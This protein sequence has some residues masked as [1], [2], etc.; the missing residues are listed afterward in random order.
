M[1]A[2]LDNSRETLKI[3]IKFHLIFIFDKMK[4]ALI[5]FQDTLLSNPSALECEKYVFAI[6]FFSLEG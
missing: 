4:I 3:V 5:I 2:I 1:E 6:T